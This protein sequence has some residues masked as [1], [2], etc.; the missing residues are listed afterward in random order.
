M[1][2]PLTLRVWT[3]R[4]VLKNPE[5]VPLLRVFTDRGTYYCGKA[6]NHAYQ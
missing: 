6:E 2:K 1:L 4:T 5:K 3:G